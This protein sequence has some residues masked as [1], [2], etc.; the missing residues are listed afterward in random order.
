MLDRNGGLKT[1]EGPSREFGLRSQHCGHHAIAWLAP[2]G[3]SDTKSWRSVASR[4]AMIRESDE[5]QAIVGQ[6]I[7]KQF[8]SG[9]SRDGNCGNVGRVGRP[10]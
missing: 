3:D 6:P 10:V 9:I 1:K 2:D 7:F 5:A 8:A 4:T